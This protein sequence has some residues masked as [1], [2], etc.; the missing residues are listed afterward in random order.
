[1]L[2]LL[3]YLGMVS[4]NSKIYSSTHLT[5]WLESSINLS[6]VPTWLQNVFTCLNVFSKE[7]S[8]NKK[9]DTPIS[10]QKMWSASGKH[11]LDHIGQFLVSLYFSQRSEYILFLV[12]TLFFLF[13]GTCMWR[14]RS[15]SCGTLA[16]YS[17]LKNAV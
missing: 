12:L 7:S 11:N 9:V 16:C 17:K 15:Q 3:V 14:T 8:T 1:M 13:W 5:H 6:E 4:L 2:V 10:V